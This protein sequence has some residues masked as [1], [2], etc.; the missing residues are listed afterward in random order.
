[1]SISPSLRTYSYRNYCFFYLI[2]QNCSVHLIEICLQ[3]GWESGKTCWTY[4]Y[5]HPNF[6]PCR[7]WN[8]NIVWLICDRF[9]NA[10]VIFDEHGIKFLFTW[11]VKIGKSFWKELTNSFDLVRDKNMLQ[12]LPLL[13]LII[14]YF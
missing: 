10:W 3:K 11:R 14:V 2:I 8:T 12:P 9:C 7:T 5:F 4:K 1:M 13:R 6:C